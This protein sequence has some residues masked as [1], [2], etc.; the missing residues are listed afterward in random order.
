MTPAD[1]LAALLVA[2]DV[3]DAHLSAADMDRLCEVIGFD[4]DD[5]V[6]EE[7]VDVVARLGAAQ[8]PGD[9]TDDIYAF[10]VGKWRIELGD[11]A[12]RAG[13][14]T[15]IASG[16]LIQRGVGEIGVA[17]ATA[18]L[19][20]VLEIEKVEVDAGDRRLLV[21]LLLKP[22]VKEGF[23]TEDELYESLPAD[24]RRI[25]N[26]YDFAR[27]V[28]RLRE[29]GLVEGEVDWL[30]IRDPDDRGPRVRIR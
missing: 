22:A 2:A 3:E 9:G 12:V 10:R 24:K 19:P 17:I 11:G 7:I 4:R 18:I 16:A 27:F 13:I 20:T 30:R 5:P 15:A 26:R 8:R 21:D 6:T 25:V 23:M 29:A 28:E 14:L 1:Q